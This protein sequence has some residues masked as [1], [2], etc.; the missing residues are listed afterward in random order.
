[1]KPGSAVQTRYLVRARQSLAV[2]V[3]EPSRD[4]GVDHPAVQV[5]GGRDDAR[6]RGARVKFKVTLR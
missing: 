2:V 3:R 6:E 1:M 5:R 4:D